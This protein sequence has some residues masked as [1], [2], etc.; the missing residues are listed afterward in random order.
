MTERE[1]PP[2]LR[3]PPEAFAREKYIH[4]LVT[5]RPASVF[6]REFERRQK[7]KELRQHKG[8]AAVEFRFVDAVYFIAQAAAAGVIGNLSYHAIASLVRAI[9]KPNRELGG[10][11]VR[12]ELVVSRKTYE[13]LRS[14]KHPG[15]RARTSLSVLKNELKTTYRLMV[16][17][18]DSV[19]RPMNRP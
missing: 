17:R 3:A 14:K 19:P 16:T 4:R 1:L 7:E 11:A 18:R 15:E 9:R 2:D 13:R 12:F 6:F 8:I 10:R 5:K